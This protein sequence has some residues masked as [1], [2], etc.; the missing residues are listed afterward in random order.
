MKRII[1]ISMLILLLTTPG[2]A[3]NV[4]KQEVAI[5]IFG[6]KRSGIYTGSLNEKGEP[7]GYG[8]EY[9]YQLPGHC[10]FHSYY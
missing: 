5:S 3:E 6:E 4:V 7:D 8:A 10:G 9:H 2:V 1:V